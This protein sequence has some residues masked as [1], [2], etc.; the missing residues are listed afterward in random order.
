[1]NA[2]LS[3]LIRIE[4]IALAGLADIYAG[5]RAALHR[6]V[7]SLLADIEAVTRD[8]ALYL[9]ENLDRLRWSVSAILGFENGNGHGK[10]QHLSWVYAASQAL[11]DALRDQQ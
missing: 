1:M 4:E 5:Q 8:R 9:G 7:R 3:A 6:D 2:T 10:E 11:Q